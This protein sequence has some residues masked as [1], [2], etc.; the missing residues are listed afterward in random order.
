MAVTPENYPE[1]ELQ[2]VS[3]RQSGTVAH[4]VILATPRYAH[5]HGST[6]IR[7]YSIP[8]QIFFREL[9]NERH[10]CIPSHSKLGSR[11]KRQRLSN[12]DS[13]IPFSTPP[14]FQGIDGLWTPEHF[15]VAAVASCFVVTFYGVAAASKLEFS[16]LH[17]DMEGKLGKPEGKLRFT[18]IILRPI[19]V[20]PPAA[21]PERAKR[22]LEKAKGNC[23][24]AL[25]LF[26]PVFME[27]QVRSVEAILATE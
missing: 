9:Q 5:R 15:L 4:F 8:K 1:N 27:P 16:S 26:C 6:P 17:V 25:S 10:T 20:V 23:L 11:K 7:R 18:E 12:G 2:R 3:Q 13:A 21:D 22:I 14:E 19:L 24:I